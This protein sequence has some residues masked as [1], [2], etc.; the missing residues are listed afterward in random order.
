[1]N[2]K[3]R[4]DLFLKEVGPGLS[5]YAAK[6]RKYFAEIQ[7]TFDYDV[8]NDTVIKCYDTICKYGLKDGE[9]ESW[10]YLFKA[11][12]M[13]SI[14][15]K[16]YARNQYRDEVEDINVVYET[17][18]NKQHSEEYKAITDLWEEFQMNYILKWV[19]YNFTKP[20]SYLF[21]LKFVLQ[22]PEKEIKQKTG[23]KKCRADINEML[24]IIRMHIKIEDIRKEFLLKYPEV[25]LD[26]LS[27]EDRAKSEQYV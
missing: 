3:Q 19:D 26:L 23:N 4:A 10:N 1:M 12:K 24:R 6:W 14:R 22:L 7:L 16:T 11:F 27:E 9:K 15:E 13:N 21:R 25:D 5:V 20:F 18:M 8:L 2:Y 17:Y